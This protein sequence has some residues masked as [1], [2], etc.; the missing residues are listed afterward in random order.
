MEDIKTEY[1]LVQSQNRENQDNF[2]LSALIEPTSTFMN[3]HLL[4]SYLLLKVK[5]LFQQHKVQIS[6][7]KLQKMRKSSQ[8]KIVIYRGS[9]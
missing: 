9:Q 7:M 3:L 1:G 8:S 4:I 2:A 6:Q 5:K